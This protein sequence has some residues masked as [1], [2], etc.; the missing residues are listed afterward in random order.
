MKKN[1]LPFGTQFTP[2]VINLR[3]ILQLIK[4][5]EGLESSHFI[6]ELIKKYFSK[7]TESSQERMAKNC[8]TSLVSY[9]ILEPGKSIFMSDFGNSLYEISDDI[10]FYDKFAIHILKNLNGL[11]L[12]DAI[13]SL[14]REGKHVT[15]E[16]IIGYL[17]NRG[18]DYKPTAN[19]AQSMKLWLERSGV[20]TKKW[21]IV[22]EK[23]NGLISLSESEIDIL[24]RLSLPQYYF[25]KTLCNIESDKYHKAS[26]VRD[27]ATA[28]YGIK[29]VEKSFS[30]LVLNPLK[31]NGLI[32]MKKTTGGRGARTPEVKLT[33]LS[34]KSII[35]PFLEQIENI[36]GK[37][38]S[39][40]YQKTLQ[41][42][43]KDV[44]SSDTYIKG[45]ALEVLAIKIMEIIGLEFIET[46]LK[47]TETGGAEVDIL[48]ESSN[49]AY[50][51]WQVQC[52][53]KKKV[54][55]GDIAKEVGLS[56]ILKTN[57]IVIMTT[58][59][60]TKAAR[61]YAAKVMT[62]MNLSIIIIEGT[63]ISDIIEEPTKIIKILNR[64]SLEAK[65]IKVLKE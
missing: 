28:T 20:L 31:E 19:N 41:E 44:D 53:N 51:R 27:L 63:D 42:I 13:R 60:V 11:L 2:N 61:E 38:R 40:Y 64:E 39:Q 65:Q 7:N 15:N 34:K 37:E 62:S 56:H 35:L 6:D 21:C 48:F 1:K 24:K 8:K 22:E 43:R 32:E 47:G 16:S 4:D 9:G 45:I 57:V 52:K 46:R 25:I 59:V 18:F 30:S 55:L 3:E 5:N 12:V 58:G 14:N 10:M 54:E 33:E 49:L 23:I 36:I 50:S 29:F 26:G 17:N